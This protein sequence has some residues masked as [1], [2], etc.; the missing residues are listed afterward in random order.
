MYQQDSIEVSS[1]H[2]I[3]N[4]VTTLAPKE[5]S[6]ITDTATDGHTAFFTTLQLITKQGIK[7]FR[8]KIDPRA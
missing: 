4:S 3:F 5:D 6:L 8:V 7:I 2:L 1:N